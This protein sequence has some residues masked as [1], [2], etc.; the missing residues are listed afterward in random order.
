MCLSLVQGD[1][2]LG[3]QTNRVSLVS[4]LLALAARSGTIV[5]ISGT[6]IHAEAESLLAGQTRTNAMGNE[7]DL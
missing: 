5:R 4:I 6:M 7:R 3:W 1:Q 2:P